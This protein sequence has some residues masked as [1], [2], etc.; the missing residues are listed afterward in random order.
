V[1]LCNA[2]C[3]SRVDGGDGGTHLGGVNAVVDDTGF[4]V[5]PKDKAA[6]NGEE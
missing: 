6:L 2:R 4:P 3:V 5:E 1:D